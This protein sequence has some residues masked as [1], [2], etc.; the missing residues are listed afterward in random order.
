MSKLVSGAK[1]MIL[2]NFYALDYL[3]FGKPI[4]EVKI[5]C[6]LIKED[7]ITKK[8]AILSLIVEM[9]KHTKASPNLKTFITEEDLH[10]KAITSAKIARESTNAVIKSNKFREQ[11]KDIIFESVV[12]D[13]KIKNLNRKVQST[14][15]SKILSIGVDNLLIARLLTETKNIHKFNDWHGRVIEDAYHILK[16]DLIDVAYVINHHE[17]E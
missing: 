10:N 6:N 7:Y 14:L 4:S 11:M 8:N 16:E 2:E 12:S 17:S 3:F 15:E 9:T 1:L 13:K 5:C